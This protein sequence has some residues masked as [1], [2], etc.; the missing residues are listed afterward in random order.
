M[1][2]V[3]MGLL[4]AMLVASVLAAMPASAKKCKGKKCKP[5]KPPVEACVPFAPGEAGTGKPVVTLTDA[6]TEAAPVEQKVTLAQSVAD[7]TQGNTDPS[8]TYFN[9]Q[10]DSAAPDAGLYALLEFDARR[11]YDLGAMYA[12]GSY[13]AQSHS[14]NTI[15]ET[16][17]QEAPVFGGVS[18]T[19]NGG[20][21]TDHS[22]ALV[23][24]RTGD[25][26][27]WT[28]EVGNYLGE[29]GDL[30]VKL[31]LGESKTDPSPEGEVT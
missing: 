5:T 18:S 16:T 17:D 9:V 2:R 10:V 11:D 27:G 14:W 23:G 26:G 31:W 7:L 15:V 12:D 22:E 1:K 21:S 20:Q 4:V 28:I 30:S 24:I 25:C 8:V 19:G 3:L 6:A 13:G 29:G